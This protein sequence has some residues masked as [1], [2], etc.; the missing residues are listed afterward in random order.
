MQAIRRHRDAVAAGAGLVLPLGVAAALVPFRAS[1]AGTAAALVLVTVIVG[2]AVFGN[3]MAGC[4]ATVS[5][6]VWFDFFLTRPYQRLAITQRA[7]LET[8]ISLFVVGLIVTE[9]AARSRHHRGVAA[10]ETDHVGLIYDV[11][12]LVA[13][14]ASVDQVL[15][16]AQSEIVRLLHLR[17]CRY[18]PGR[19]NRPRHHI[20][21]DGH[22]ILAGQVWGVQRVGL[23]GPEIELPV[24]SRGRTLGRF[25]LRPTPGYPVSLQRRLVAVAMADQVGA[26]LGPQA[27]SA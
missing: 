24:D 27:L 25:V 26:A 2:V 23:P 3:R 11:S 18:E 1:F 4:I 12:E 5:A 17:E 22:V 10:E 8:A 20:G 6:T 13:S 16:R 15:G 7:D 9:L 14:G 19:P 21:H